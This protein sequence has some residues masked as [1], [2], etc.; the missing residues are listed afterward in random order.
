VHT[1][2]TRLVPISLALVLAIQAEAQSPRLTGARPP[3][4]VVFVCEH[5]SVK[6][7]VASVYFN[8]RAQE[9]GLPYR[10][11]ARGVSPDST[12]PSLVREGL[13]GD[14]FKVSDFVPQLFQGSDADHA[15]LVVSFDQEITKMV[16][17]RTRYLKWDDLPGVLADYPRGRDAIVRHIDALVDELTHSGLP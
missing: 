10:A 3:A 4:Q 1:I 8:R 5:G 13:Q 14:G 6:S 17:G 12:V 16:D 2:A 7:L 11:V 15:A 9:G